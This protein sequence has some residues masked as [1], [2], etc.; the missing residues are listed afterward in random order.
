MIIR[1]S[2]ADTAKNLTGD[3]ANTRLFTVQSWET[4]E[5]MV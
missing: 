2:V 3:H 1:V 5:L 4:I